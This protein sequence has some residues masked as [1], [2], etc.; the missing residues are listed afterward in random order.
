MITLKKTV[1]IL[2]V[3]IS[4]LGFSAPKVS[5]DQPLDTVSLT[6]YASRTVAPDMA[7]VAFSYETQG[8]SIEAVRQDGAVLSNKV[9]AKILSLGIARTDLATTRYTVAPTYTYGKNGK[10]MLTGYELYATWTV[11]VN[12]LNQLGNVVDELLGLG[13][14]RIDSVSYGVKSADVYRRQLMAE[15]VSNARLNAAAIAEAGGRGLGVL[16]QASISQ[17]N[18]TMDAAPQML[19]RAKNMEAVGAASTELVPKA[20]T[21]SVTVNTVFAMTLE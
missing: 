12:D 13:V 5:A 3:L 10:Q 8:K 17:A 7:T 20:Y 11:K 6:G 21:I 2:A 18:F 14:N 15:A 16:R 19:M 4:F 9:L 1:A